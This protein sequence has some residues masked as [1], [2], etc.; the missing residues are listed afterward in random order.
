MAFHRGWDRQNRPG[1]FGA[2]QV[3][4]KELLTEYRQ[5]LIDAPFG[6][7]TAEDAL[8]NQS[9]ESVHPMEAPVEL[10]AYAIYESFLNGHNCLGGGGQGAARV[11]PEWQIVSEVNG[12]MIVN[13]PKNEGADSVS[14]SAG[15][16]WT[17]RATHRFCPFAQMLFSGRRLT[18][19]VQNPELRETLLKE[20]NDGELAHYPKRSAYQDEYQAL[21]FQLTIG[22]G[23]DAAFGRAFSWHVLDLD[24]SH[25]WLPE[26]HSISASNSVQLRTGVVLY[27][28]TW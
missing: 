21:G 10:Q 12:C 25:S 11:N 2:S 23:V 19:E 1:L 7:H 15:P 24:Y 5:G 14:F 17:P 20:W 13:T 6:P 22:G 8:M 9:V 26:V 16:R 18:Y 27:I 4:R 3:L 28:G